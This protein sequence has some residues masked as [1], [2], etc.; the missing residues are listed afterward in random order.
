[1]RAIMREQG[2]GKPLWLT[3]TGIYTGPAGVSE[4][5][6]TE[7]IVKSEI[8]WVSMGVQKTIQLALKD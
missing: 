8:R 6:Q 7:R 3:E 1:M 2:D 4:E 5:V